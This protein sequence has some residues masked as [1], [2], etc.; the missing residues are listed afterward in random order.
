MNI[1]A[2]VFLGVL[3]S[4]AFGQTSPEV[5]RLVQP[6]PTETPGRIEVIEFFWY[7][8]PHCNTLEPLLEA[9][10][11]GLPGDV[12]LRRVPVIWR[13]RDE[14]GLHARLFLTLQSMDLLPGYHRAVFE[15]LHGAKQRIRNDRQVVE[16]AASQGIERSMFDAAYRSSGVRA[17]WLRTRNI[18][19]D[20][21]VESV[22][23]FAVNGKFWV[24]VH[25]ERAVFATLDELIAA[26]RPKKP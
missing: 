19:R 7:G 18:T 21:Q 5:I 9:W 25:D 11:K 2:A 4:N 14:T 12:V 15:T 8:C 10:E 1:Y 17:Q 22:P 13:G 16:W 3:A 26:E 6:Q 23:S 24:K 20:Y